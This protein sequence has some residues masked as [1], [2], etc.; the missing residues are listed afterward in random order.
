M[1]MSRNIQKGIILSLF[2]SIFA[3]GVMLRINN[4][5]NVKKRS[6]DENIYTAQAK[7]LT[8]EGNA[9]LKTLIE[10]YNSTP[11]AWLR[12]PPTRIG[13][14]WLLAGAMKL[15]NNDS[16]NTGAYI[17]T[18][19]SVLSL[20]FITVIGLR[21]FNQ[22]TALTALL[23]LSVSPMELAIARRAWQ[24]AMFG[25][26]GLML[27]YFCCEIIHNANKIVWYILL[28][29]LGSY[30]VLIK[31][32]ALIVY[33][34]C[35]LWILWMCIAKQK[36]FLKALLLSL[37]G[38]VGIIISV[39]ALVISAGGLN[40]IL[41]LYK[42]FIETM[43]A[44][45]YAV[46]Y[47]SGPWYYLLGGLWLLSPVNLF[48]CIVGIFSG[49]FVPSSININ[50]NA[51]RG[52]IF[53]M[54]SFIGITI[55]TPYCQNVRY[56]SPVFAPFY[57]ISCLGLWQVIS[58]ANHRVKK[59]HFYI[60]TTFILMVVVSIATNEYQNFRKIFVKGAAMD[61]APKWIQ[62]TSK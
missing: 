44:N 56:I 24:D 59:H 42:H 55:V 12:P 16:V 15:T 29:V 49:I 25:C 35:M 38:I 50:K 4:L 39:S 9:G 1:V 14:L 3:V 17:S 43:P 8:L 32:S 46:E 18:F 21:F 51:V 26:W 45:A 5:G 60:I 7:V 48:L 27:I 53:F 37:S 62:L 41:T 20:L 23:F 36:H 57:L 33:G 47:Q 58:F 31:E 6:T 30:C 52:I 40:P 13:Y 28:L 54:V 10:A 2:I 22:W 34:L 11:T 19:F 61:L